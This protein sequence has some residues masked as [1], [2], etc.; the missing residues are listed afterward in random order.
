[1]LCHQIG[2]RTNESSPL[3]GLGEVFLALGRPEEA[4]AQFAAASLAAQ[5][6]E[7]RELARAH[8]GLASV[9][10]TTG[11]LG[12]ACGHCKEAIALYTATG[13]A[14]AD[15]IS[16]TLLRLEARVQGE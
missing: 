7:V 12:R 11:D 5:I 14:E 8:S 9:Y 10:H 4:R 15:E 1:M 6:G 2:N 3:N 16:D 13:A